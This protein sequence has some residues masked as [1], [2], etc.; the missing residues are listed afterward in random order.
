MLRSLLFFLTLQFILVANEST[1]MTEFSTQNADIFLSRNPVTEVKPHFKHIPKRVGRYTREDWQTAIDTTWG[2]GLPI[3]DKLDAFDTYMEFVDG[4]YACF[5]NLDVEWDALMRYREEIAA[6]VSAGR[7]SG[8][9]SHVIYELM[10]MHTW[11]IDLDIAYDVLEPGVPIFRSSGYWEVGH[12]GAAL[13]PISDSSLVVY[14]VVENHP[15]NLQQGDVVLGYD[16]VPYKDLYPELL[17]A[18]LPWG[19]PARWGT[20]ESSMTHAMLTGAGLNW[21][22]FDT[23]DVVKHASG[24]TVH[25]ATAPLA[26]EEMSIYALESIDVPGVPRPDWDNESDVSWGMVEGTQIGYI[27]VNSWSTGWSAGSDFSAAVR[28]LMVNHETEGLII[29]FRMQ[30]GGSAAQA[31]A[32]FGKLFGVNPLEILYDRRANI[33]DHFAMEP[34]ECSLIP[35]SVDPGWYEK[36]IAVLLGPHCGSSGD[37]NALRIISH[38]MVRTFGKATNGSFLCNSINMT[39]ALP[40]PIAGRYVPNN[41][42]LEDAPGEYLMHVGFE[43]DEEIWLT[44]EDVANNFDTVVGRAMEWLQSKAYAYDISTDQLCYS[45]EGVDTIRISAKTVTPDQNIVSLSINMK[46]EFGSIIDSTD[47]YDDGTH[48]DITTDDG[49]CTGFILKPVSEG[50]YPY[51]LRFTDSTGGTEYV[52]PKIGYAMTAGPLVFDEITVA[53]MDHPNPGASYLFYFNI[54]N[55]G[56]TASVGDVSAQIFSRDETLTVTTVPRS[57]GNL[58]AGESAQSHTGNYFGV[59]F[60]SDSIVEAMDYTLDLE[61]YSNDMHFWTDSL[62]VRLYPVGISAEKVMP[63]EYSLSQNF[64]NP[65]NSNTTINY[66]LPENELVRLIVY[67]MQGRSVRLLVDDIHT[68]GEYRVTWDGRDHQGNALS[69]GV[70]FARFSAGAH[71]D[72]I[73]MM[74]IK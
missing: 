1:V 47:L 6:G 72:V 67:D 59:H 45:G 7:F 36:P 69:T 31:D 13:T 37:L 53:N 17:D 38:P 34:S 24:D 5:Q 35:L 21:H 29:D 22:L 42:Y 9:L 25:L 55:L 4:Y 33:F 44:Q 54:K 18:Q 15:L 66:G 41:G 70:Y 32:G 30:D 57:F 39:G 19:G 28:E 62:T 23:L 14:A 56:E 71:N 50:C 11:V 40:D 2:E 68:R 3:E 48:G 46:D 12:F 63:E 64:P 52:I 51:D 20:T 43:V 49:M 60:A 8:I 27:Y 10:E 61:I 16:G 58:V 65:F 73:K 74:L 26:D